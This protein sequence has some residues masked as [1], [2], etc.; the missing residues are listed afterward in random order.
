M[1]LGAGVAIAWID[2]RP[3]WDDT[4]LSAGLLFLAA[5]GAAALRAPAWL[6]ALLVAA[7]PVIAEIRGGSGVLLAIPIALL[8]ALAGLVLRRGLRTT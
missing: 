2:T 3:H 7:P 1:A 5:A 6:A 4:G 8:G